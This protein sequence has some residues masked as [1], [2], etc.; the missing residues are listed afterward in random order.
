MKRTS[1]G[2]V[3][4]RFQVARL[5]KGHRYLIDHVNAH[6]DITI[7]ALGTSESFPTKKNPLSFETRR[8]ML[9]GAYPKAR[10]IELPDTKLDERWSQSLDATIEASVPTGVSDPMITLY[11]SR[12]SFIGCYTGRYSTSIVPPL[13]SLNGTRERE[14]LEKPID[15]VR[16]REGLIHAQV[17]R[18]PAVY[19]TVDIAIVRREANEVL[20]GGKDSDGDKLRFVG[21]FVDPKDESYEHAARRE[22]YEETAGIEIADLKQIGSTRINDWRYRDTDDVVITTLFVATYVFGPI[23]AGDDLDRLMWVPTGSLLD[24]I[25]PEHEALAHMLLTHLNQT[26]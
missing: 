19:P 26:L 9:A 13:G 22:A 2:V 8:L 10:I 17:I 20:L 14:R 12:D 15:S 5:H 4:A 3:V 16:F 7:I 25:A 24:R 11:G 6:S 18:M 23:R 21:G 1:I